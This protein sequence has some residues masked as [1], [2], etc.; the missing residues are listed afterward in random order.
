MVSEKPTRPRARYG[1]S[2][3]KDNTSNALGTKNIAF[4][5]F[6]LIMVAVF[7]VVAVFYVQQQRHSDAN[8]VTATERGFQTDSEDQLTLFMDVTRTTPE[9]D[10][11]CVVRALD[12]DKT[13]VGRREIFIPAGS[14][15]TVKLSVPIS[16]RVRAV[17]GDIYGCG[18][19][20]PSYLK[21]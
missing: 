4:K 5:A 20:I 15:P 21:G 18:T 19:N 2:D 7:A 17:A 6:V 14:A 9:M 1:A 10:S 16:T 8:T 11:F 3:T 13:E 12:Y